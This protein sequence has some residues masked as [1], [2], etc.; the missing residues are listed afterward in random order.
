MIDARDGL[1]AVQGQLAQFFD[2]FAPYPCVIRNLPI[3]PKAIEWPGPADD[4]LNSS[5]RK[6][7]LDYL[8]AHMGDQLYHTFAST[9]GSRRF[10][11]AFDCRNEGGYKP[12]AIAE[13]CKMTFKEFMPL[14]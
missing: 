6:W 11:Y 5:P 1:A 10:A 14:G 13:A 2:P 8:S 3:F 9:Q 4:M 12:A 7:S